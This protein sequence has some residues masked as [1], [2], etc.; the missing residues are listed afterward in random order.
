[1]V[2]LFRLATL[3]SLC[4]LPFAETA[5][6]E[7]R[8]PE[9]FATETPAETAAAVSAIRVDKDGILWREISKA[10]RVENSRDDSIWSST[11]VYRANDENGSPM[12]EVVYPEVNI[13]L[14]HSSAQKI[15][16]KEEEHRYLSEHYV[17]FQKSSQSL[18]A[19]RSGELSPSLG[20]NETDGNATAELGGSCGYPTY[21][22]RVSY[23]SHCPSRYACWQG[24]LP[25][26]RTYDCH[27]R[28]EAY[29]ETYHEAYKDPYQ[30]SYQERYRSGDRCCGWNVW[31][32]CT[33]RCDRW[34]SRTSY[35]WV[36]RTSY[37]WVSRT[38]Y[39]WNSCSYQAWSSYH[40]DCPNDV[41]RCPLIFDVKI[42]NPVKDVASNAVDFGF[43]VIQQQLCG[44]NCLTSTSGTRRMVQI[45]VTVRKVGHACSS[46][47]DHLPCKRWDNFHDPY[48]GGK[49]LGLTNAQGSVDVGQYEIAYNVLHGLPGQVTHEG[50]TG[51]H[52]FSTTRGCDGIMPSSSIG[53]QTVENSELI[54]FILLSTD[55]F[56]NTPCEKIS[57]VKESIFREIDVNVTDGVLTYDEIARAVRK[58]G[59]DSYVLKVWNHTR[60]LRVSIGQFMKTSVI[61]HA[62]AS[63]YRAGQ[64]VTFS[65]T[66]YPSIDPGRMTTNKQ[67]ADDAKKMS[68]AW[69]YSASVPKQGDIVCVFVDGLLFN[70]NE[71]SLS[72]PTV[73]ADD[74][75]QGSNNLWMLTKMTDRRPVIGGMKETLPSLVAQFTFDSSLFY[76]DT[77]GE[78]RIDSAAPLADG[79]TFR[80]SLQSKVGRDEELKGFRDRD[81]RGTQSK[82]RSG[83]TCQNWDTQSPHEHTNKRSSDAGT[84]SNNY[85]R[86]PDDASTI[87]CYTTDP[88]TRW[89]YCDPVPIV[90]Q[91][92]PVPQACSGASGGKCVQPGSTLVYKGEPFQ[93]SV[94]FSTWVR[95]STGKYTTIVEFSGKDGRGSQ[96]LSLSLDATCGLKIEHRRS[97]EPPKHLPL[98]VSPGTWTLVG[99]TLSHT[100]GMTLFALPIDSTSVVRMN[101]AQWPKDTLTKMPDIDLLAGQST[102]EFDDIRFHTGIMDLSIFTA[103]RECGRARYCAD[104]A[105]ATPSH[106]RVVCVTANIRGLETQEPVCTSALYY[107]GTAIDI[108]ASMDMA[109]VVFAFRDTNWQE[110]S[111]EIERRSPS[112]DGASTFDTVVLVEG[113]LKGCAA[114]F[115]SITYMDRDASYT[116]YKEWLYRITTKNPSNAASPFL[117]SSQI[118]FRTPWKSL[119]EGRVLAGASTTG[120]RNVRL[121]AE[122]DTFISH[123]RQSDTFVDRN[124]TTI[125]LAAYKSTKHSNGEKT[126]TAYIVTDGLEDGEVVGM[127]IDE[128][129]R[130]DLGTWSSV[131]TVAV[132]YKNT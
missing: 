71:P 23:L 26:Y 132:C 19:E 117:V 42:N 108:Q 95:C 87:W 96:S 13:T 111:F 17:E 107:D 63:A 119:L 3:L 25:K 62:C 40:H 110:S 41:G 83:R 129:I 37:R 53:H 116:P 82:T 131:S 58:N 120:V 70:R 36:S 102:S 124:T 88:A 115:S 59:G 65:S 38:R 79:Q 98:R 86:N 29:Q 57:E 113:D 69:K 9:Y 92:V 5:V 32:S 101:D 31:G 106:R 85:C 22:C 18:H 8:A 44:G 21:Y 60:E 16:T 2:T 94:A 46:Y 125:N 114:K 127:D 10:R 75:A 78:T 52:T 50:V 84:V 91:R 11:K 130:V 24:D 99:F 15:P 105:H 73:N 56:V 72:K 7:S 123:Q 34:S 4:V 77:V 20:M 47:G 64:Q 45:S 49:L 68:L 67:C 14:N 76:G 109:G 122:F 43:E 28:N 97:G 80:P 93:D 48:F 90:P 6:G 104:R 89:E 39:K 27:G 121:C 55:K 100:N 103:S 30:E 128:Y 81:Y 35:R 12:F 33:R 112:L 118:L 51:K 126:S 1:M 74:Y 66:V 61:P 54:K